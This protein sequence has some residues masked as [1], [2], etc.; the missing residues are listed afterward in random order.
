VAADEEVLRRHGFPPGPVVARAPRQSYG[1]AAAAARPDVLV[2]DDCESIGGGAEMTSPQLPRA[3][4][5]HVRVLVVAEFGGLEGLP[6]E[7][8]AS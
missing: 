6:E 8:W 5:E 7:P 3:L 1:E 4:R 2:E